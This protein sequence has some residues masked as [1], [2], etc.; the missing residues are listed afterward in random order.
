MVRRAHEP[1]KGLWSLPGGKVRAGERI[2][3]AL[4]REIAE[5]TGVAVTVRD[6]VGVFEVV[7]DDTHYVVLDYLVEASGEGDPVAAG[8]AADARWVPLEEVT[9]LDCTPRFVETLR[10]WGVLAAP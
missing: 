9:A 1:G 3:D 4:A 8:D 2:A 10:G 7:G 5:E 6:L